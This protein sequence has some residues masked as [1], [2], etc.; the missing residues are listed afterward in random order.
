M[1]IRVPLGS[2]LFTPRAFDAR[3]IANLRPTWWGRRQNSRAPPPRHAHVLSACRRLAFW[4]EHRRMSRVRAQSVPTEVSA[5]RHKSDCR[6]TVGEDQQG[7]KQG[8]RLCGLEG[9]SGVRCSDAVEQ[10]RLWLLVCLARWL[11]RCRSVVVVQRP[12]GC[13]QPCAH[14]TASVS[15]TRE[16]REEFGRYDRIRTRSDTRT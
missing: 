13:S 12:A 16:S 11:A 8:L 1:P 7:L 2:G 5:E 6:S 10:C 15:P 14:A 9:P 4:S 3:P